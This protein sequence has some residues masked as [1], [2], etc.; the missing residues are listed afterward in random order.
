MAFAKDTLAKIAKLLKLK[1]EDVE[2][3]AT[4][5]DE[6][7]LAIDDNLQ[8]FT[9]DE[10]TTLKN[11]EYANGKKTGV[12]MAVKEVKEKVG[13]EF[14]GKTIDGLLEAHGKKV[15]ADAK[16]EPEKKVAEMEEKL[17]ALQT[18]YQTLEKTVQEKDATV[19]R[20]KVRTAVAKH[21]PAPGENGPALDQ[22]EIIDLMLSKGYDFKQDE[23][24][25]VVA[26]KDGKEVTDKLSQPEDV[27]NVV[28][29]F[30][31]EKKLI[32]DDVTPGGRGGGNGKAPAKFTKLSELKAH[33][34]GQGKSTIG[35]EFMTEASKIK[36][37]DPEFNLS[38]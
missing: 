13:L 3:V 11:N 9:G 15:L 17:K 36:A 4:A 18:N 19:A 14:Q 32:V 27:K 22:D 34:E 28:T 30:L 33:Y 1:P 38:N 35:Q 29:G 7:E 25:K 31:K 20:V 16:I 26:Y 10:I 21:I 12:E 6:K 24:G 2:A 23:T 37:A 8:T 5:T